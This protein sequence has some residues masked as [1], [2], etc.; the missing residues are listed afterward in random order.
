VRA[1]EAGGRVV[2]FTAES[3]R[4]GDKRGEDREKGRT[5]AEKSA[6]EGWLRAG[7]FGR[8]E[9]VFSVLSASSAFSGFDVLLVFSALVSVTPCLR[10]ECF[11]TGRA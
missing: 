5:E 11:I 10:G 8:G 6:A 4:N 2:E 1:V 7:P 3:L 9:T